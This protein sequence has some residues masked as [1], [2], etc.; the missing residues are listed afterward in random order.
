MANS[1]SLQSWI[2]LIVSSAI[3][4][5]SF[6]LMKKGL[7]A[8]TP[9]QVASFRIFLA[10]IIFLP[11][12]ISCLK[13]VPAKTLWLICLVAIMGTGIPPYL[14]TTAQTVVDSSTAGIL[15]SLTPVFALIV[16]SLFFDQKLDKYK[17][18]GVIL[19]FA[20]ILFVFS[21]EGI[22]NFSMNVFAL[23]IVLATVFYAFSSTMVK[24]YFGQLDPLH[25]TALVLT[26]IAVP[27]G[28]V[29]FFSDPVSSFRN[30]GGME[31]FGYILIL[32]LIN[33]SFANYLFYKMIQKS[34]ALFAQ[35]VTYLIPVVALLLGIADGENIGIPEYSGMVLILGGIYLIN[36]ERK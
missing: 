36:Y 30:P 35:S 22:L 18:S 3:W 19:G 14:F 4:G 27:G 17:I 8:F 20:G 33:T 6:L 9:V 2:L 12:A 15:N 16:G 13:K 24:K 34:T 10:G 5:S 31:A 23:L 32:A 29:L 28:V 21:D 25:L 7:V 1:A 11:V 26:F